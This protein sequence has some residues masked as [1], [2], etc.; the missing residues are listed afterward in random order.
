VKGEPV[1]EVLVPISV[2]ELLDK[3]TILQIKS[4]RIS[5]PAKLV[6]INKER[7]A[8]IE[9]CKSLKVETGHRLVLDLQQINESLWV[10]EDKLREKE[11]QKAFDEEFI[12]L[13]RDVYFTN[14]RRAAVKREI[15][16]LMGSTYIE[17]KSYAPYS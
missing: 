12:Q 3:L 7:L 17:E 15:N 5:D 14:D 4:Q 16:V 9:T 11:H 8:L 2:G 10:V 1:T 6:N 13:A